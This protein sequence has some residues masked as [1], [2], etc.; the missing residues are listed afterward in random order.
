MQFNSGVRTE[1]N[2]FYFPNKDRWSFSIFSL[3]K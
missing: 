3:M 1:K 2:T